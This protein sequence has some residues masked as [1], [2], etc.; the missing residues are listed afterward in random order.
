MVMHM[1]AYGLGR[2]VSEVPEVT[3]TPQG[4]GSTVLAECQAD[5]CEWV[6]FEVAMRGDEID[7]EIASHKKWHE[8]G[9][10]P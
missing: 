1:Y 10:Q 8:E 6:F 4:N 2:E 7:R 5:H 9:M 3:V